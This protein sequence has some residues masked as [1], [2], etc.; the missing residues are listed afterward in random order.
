VRYIF[1]YDDAGRLIALADGD[2]NTTTI[3]HNASGHPTAIVGP[4][5]QR[6]TLAVDGTGY[7]SQITNPA[8]ET[9]QL[10]YSPEG[11]LTSI[12]D[13]RG[14]HSNF[15]YDSVGRLIQDTD[16]EGGIQTLTRTGDDRNYAVTLTSSLSHTT[17]YQVEFL[18]DGG[19]RRRNTFPNGLSTEWIRR[20]DDV[21]A[22]H[23]PDGTAMQVER[24]PDPRWGMQAPVAT[25]TIITTPAGLR[26]SL[27]I[28][29]TATLTNPADLFSLDTTTETL[30]LNGRTVSSVY[31]AADRT[32]TIT[33]PEGRHVIVSVDRL[34]RPEQSQVDGLLPVRY[35]YDSRG[36]IVAASSGVGA[37]E[38]TITFTYDSNGFLS[39]ISDPLGR[40]TYFTYDRA[41]RVTRQTL[42]DGRVIQAR[43]DA[44]G[45]LVGLTPPGRPEHIFA[46]TALDQPSS[47]T[48][49]DVNPGPDETTYTYNL[50]RQLTQITRPDGGTVDL[51]YD[52]AGRLD[53]LTFP[54]GTI[55]YQ[56]D[57]GTGNVAT[58]TAPGGLGLTYRYDGMLLTGETWTGAV[59]GS[60]DYTYDN[61]YRIT[62]SQINGGNAIA[63]AYDDDDLMRQAGAL[64]LGHDAQTGLLTGTALGDVITARGYNAFGE[65]T[66]DSAAYLGAAVYAVQYTRDKLGRISQKTETIGGV[67]ST[68]TYTYDATDRL[69]RVEKNG[70][71]VEAYTYDDNGN[72]LSATSTSG[73]T[74]GS[75]DNQDRLIQYGNTIYAYT[76]NGE[77]LS[78]TTGGQA[79]TYSYDALGNLAAVTL[80]NGS[81]IGYQIDGR[82]R[83]V[84]KTV[85]GALVQGFL[86]E[87]QLSPVAELD[88]ANTIVS[89]FVYASRANVPDY[90][91]KGGVTYRIIADHLGSPRLV[92]NTATGQV[93]QRLDYD[94]FG[95]VIGDTNP[96]FQ[97]FGFA[98]GLYDRNT[99][100]TRFGARDYDAETG[101]WT[102][103]DPI[104]F[105]G[106]DSN[107][108][109]YVLSDPV[110]HVDTWGL[111]EWPAWLKNLLP[112]AVGVSV[113]FD[114][115]IT[116]VYGGGGG[117]VGINPQWTRDEGFKVYRYN[118]TSDTGAL[119]YSTGGSCQYVFGW[120][121]GP[122]E[123][124]FESLQGSGGPFTLGTFRSRDRAWH[125]ITFGG[126]AGYPGLAN[127]EADYECLF[128]CN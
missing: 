53:T 127:V 84:G 33:S 22:T 54:R 104:G 89:R 111:W 68:Y 78:K 48:P 49:P 12:T 16:P 20:A 112:T 75:Y 95:N 83:R 74:S 86:Y 85:G 2:G 105:A 113:E 36:R 90:M 38:R 4:Y 50:D 23:Y 42:P 109:G 24:G 34:E 60:V 88:G 1:S 125:G 99:K 29:R 31:R 70:V 57:P 19:E 5:G 117:V 71:A 3:E 18:P 35:S 118:P 7:L 66:S 45:N 80:P 37:D 100:L 59:A 43:Y 96:G 62:S 9:I 106:G 110:N 126:S 76:P 82:N 116:G 47:Y 72:R 101:R 91:I 41:G 61:S 30:R 15:V 108:Y 73:T 10:S 44:S 39:T 97:P 55:G 79:T 87:G 107:L 11:L 114:A 40:S 63:F 13:P 32:F 52:G 6:T 69:T 103:K 119:G 46:Y 27:A 67:T 64:T 26:A 93:V 14:N 21:R 92:V 123:G 115:I 51:G 28:T 8:G 124:V 98:G 128:F 94:T 58:I 77:L 25:T 121:Q 122:W 56:Y 65:P 81:Q 102:T 120:G 17:T